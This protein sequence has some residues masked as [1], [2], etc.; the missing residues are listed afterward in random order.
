MATGSNADVSVARGPTGSR[1]RRYVYSGT[2]RPP[3]AAPRNNRR[4]LRQRISAFNF[5]LSIFV[6][7]VGIVLYIHNMLAVNYLVMEVSQLRSRLDSLSNVEARLEADVSRKSALD[8]IGAVAVGELG[9]R[10]PTGQ[11]GVLEID[12]ER[13]HRIR[14]GRTGE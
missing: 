3:G 5:I 9:L 11:P 12:P 1:E 4:I 14:E 8:K 6:I 13:L 10:H 2:G 7:G